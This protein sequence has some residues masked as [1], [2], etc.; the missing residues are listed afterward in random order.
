MTG[1]VKEDILCRIGEL[2]AFVN[3]GELTFKP[4]LLRKEEF[5]QTSK[6]YNYID[7]NQNEK[8]IPLNKN[9]LA[10]TYCQ[11]PIIYKLSKTKNITIIFNNNQQQN[12]EGLSLDKDTSSE[13]FMRTGKIKKIIVSITMDTFH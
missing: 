7:V 8:Q 6:I 1:Q 12:I 4:S 9:S 5:L 3:K 13:V 11:V 10:F 2:G